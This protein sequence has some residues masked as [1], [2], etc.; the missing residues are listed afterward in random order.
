MLYPIFRIGRSR[1]EWE[2]SGLFDRAKIRRFRHGNNPLFSLKDYRSIEKGKDALDRYREDVGDLEELGFGFVIDG[3]D[4]LCFLPS[5]AGAEKAASIQQQRAD[6]ERRAAIGGNNR[7][8]VEC[9]CCHLVLLQTT[10]DYDPASPVKGHMLAN[11]GTAAENNWS[12]EFGPECFGPN[13][14]CTSCSAQLLD[15]ATGKFDEKQLH[16]L[17]A[18]E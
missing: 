18:E 12:A 2:K 13:I 4:E 16:P 8:A 15:P 17:T 9:P 6:D 3:E 14:T 5:R 10:A 1:V 7:F 11:Y